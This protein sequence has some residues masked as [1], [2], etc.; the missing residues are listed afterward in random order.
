MQVADRGATAQ[1]Q[2]FNLVW[3]RSQAAQR[4]ENI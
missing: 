4:L 1:K 3:A 2:T